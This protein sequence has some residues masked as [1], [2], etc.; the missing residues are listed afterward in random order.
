M[1]YLIFA[2]YF[3]VLT[4]SDCHTVQHNRQ[5]S[6][7]IFILNFIHHPYDLCTNTKLK[8]WA[9]ICLSYTPDLIGHPWNITCADEAVL[10]TAAPCWELLE[11]ILLPMEFIDFSTRNL[12]LEAVVCTYRAQTWLISFTSS[13]EFKSLWQWSDNRRGEMSIAVWKLIMVWKEAMNNGRKV[14]NREIEMMKYN[15]KKKKKYI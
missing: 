11:S 6:T 13:S 7:D 5:I 1:L 14:K 2:Y 15:K 3:S 12:D 8:S 4:Y 9:I 10:T